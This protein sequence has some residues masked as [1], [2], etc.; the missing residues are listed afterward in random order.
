MS[1]LVLAR[2]WRPQAFADMT[3]Q[4]H[5][6]RTLSNAI[7]MDRVA[8]AFLFC[9]PRGVGKT[10]AA[11]LLAR[12][13]NCEKGPTDKPCGTCRA[14]TEIVSGSSVDVAE[15]D[16]ASNNSVEDVRQIRERVTYLPQR[17]RH[18]IYIIDEVHMLS[19]A[20]FNALLKTLEEPPPHV[21][22]IFAT[23]EPHKLP[24]TILSRCQRHNFRRISTA[25]MVAR[26]T[27]IVKAEKAVLSDRALALIVRQS[28][29]GMRDALSL[30]D[31]IL[32]A[33]GPTP[34]D[35]GVAE[36][37]GAV[38][39]TAVQ[40]MCEALVRRDGKALLARV[41]GLYLRGVDF[42]RLAEE[43]ALHLRHLLVARSVGEA[44]SELTDSEQKA[45]LALSK[46]SDPA[47]L[48]RLFDLVHGGV[49]EV[50]R[51]P[52]PRLALEVVLLKGIHLAPGASVSELL[53]RV[54]TLAKRFPSPSSTSH[55]PAAVGG[56]PAP[57][58]FR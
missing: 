21:K 2:K 32:S 48:T 29:G 8:H 22:F 54:E 57:E 34:T 23:T 16:G 46:E 56:R 25:R 43:L 27:E 3:G 11:R 7:A 30:L 44:P 35:E 47:Q 42:K 53:A 12:A 51:A 13:L 50:A 18:K 28:E 20:A 58:P 19:S 36:A 37:L 14:C 39:R 55:A 49:W 1:Y 4:E 38:D 24:D 41:D 40:E 45:V 17:D 31:M 10:T 9:G 5:V 33:C 6:V 26:L 15:I 52:Q